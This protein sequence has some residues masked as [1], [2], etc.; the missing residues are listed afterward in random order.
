M[1]FSMQLYTLFYF[2]YPLFR[3]SLYKPE[4]KSMAGFQREL[5]EKRVKS[6]LNREASPYA[7]FVIRKSIK[8]RQNF[9]VCWNEAMTKRSLEIKMNSQEN[10]M[11]V[12]IPQLKSLQYR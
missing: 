10:G 2:C 8:T 11:S 5:E 9:S 3:V 4:L 6:E 12:V 1:S 7:K